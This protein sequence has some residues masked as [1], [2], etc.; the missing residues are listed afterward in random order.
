MKSLWKAAEAAAYKG[1]VGQRVYTS[2]LL[3][4]EP[5]LVLQG[6]AA[7]ANAGGGSG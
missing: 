1:E 2:R 5:A 3:G 6:L 7:W 4:S